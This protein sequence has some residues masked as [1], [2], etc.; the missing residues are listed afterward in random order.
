MN[1]LLGIVLLCAQVA[2]KSEPENIS[3]NWVS[4]D[5]GIVT[6]SR[7]D[8]GRYCG[9]FVGG[10]KQVTGSLDLQW[11]L[12]ERRSTGSWQAEDGCSGRISLRPVDGALEGARTSNKAGRRKLGVPELSEFSWNIAGAGPATDQQKSEM[13]STE[14]AEWLAAT[15]NVQVGYSGKAITDWLEEFEK[16]TIT[17]TEVVD[18]ASKAISSHEAIK[19]FRLRSQYDTEIRHQMTKWVAM[20]EQTD[21]R[22]LLKRIARAIV[23]ISGPRHQNQAIDHLNRIAGKHPE[24]SFRKFFETYSAD[25]SILSEPF[26][27]LELNSEL[28]SVVSK[29]LSEGHS[30]QRLMM[31]IVFFGFQRNANDI[32]FWTQ[33]NSAVLIPALLLA[34][35]DENELVRS[36]SLNFSSQ[37]S[38]P[39]ISARLM[40][41]AETD[42]SPS[43]RGCASKWLLHYQEFTPEVLAC[44]TSVI[45]SDPEFGVKA[46]ALNH[47]DL[48]H[49]DYELIHDTLMKWARSNDTQMMQTVIQLMQQHPMKLRRPMAIDEIMDLLS[50]PEWAMHARLNLSSLNDHFECVRQYAIAKL[51]S[52]EHLAVCAL[53]VLENETHP[54][55]ARFARSAIDNIQGYCSDLPLESLQ[56][57]WRFTDGVFPDNTPTFLRLA[58][59]EEQSEPVILEVAGTEL[60][61]GGECVGHL[62]KARSNPEETLFV[63]LGKDS[64]QQRFTCSVQLEEESAPAKRRSFSLRLIDRPQGFQPQ[65]REELYNFRRAKRQ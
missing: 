23:R 1:G 8:P 55:T 6:L 45:E 4:Q 37:L 33:K 16:S 19:Y 12:E 26:S 31:L 22:A 27:I 53:P 52:F 13:P 28:A 14:E 18:A 46:E 29:T 41:V 24:A 40:E 36:Y 61:I 49:P 60:R 21:D 54:A 56:G 15:E 38:D 50:D 3:G 10:M 43:N 5:W 42:P 63:L 65:R 59:G 62:S 44:V 51:G 57:K 25:D 35:S 17:Q 2:D 34:S 47:L 30:D 39:R 32:R 48:T 9:T 7:K 64:L 20:A 58:P 11:S